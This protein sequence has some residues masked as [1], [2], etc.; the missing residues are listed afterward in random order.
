MPSGPSASASALQP[1]V[2]SSA[3][4]SVSV[5]IRCFLYKPFG[6]I[7]NLNFQIGLASARL[8]KQ[9]VVRCQKIIGRRAFRRCQMQGVQRSDVPFRQ[10]H[11]RRS[12]AGVSEMCDKASARSNPTF[13][14]LSLSGICESSSSMMS[15]PMISNSPDPASSKMLNTASAS[16]RTRFCDWSS[17]GR[18]KQQ[19]SR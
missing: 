14:R 12:I 6:R 17:K 9:I 19:T 7:F 3:G 8:A 10:F 11:A 1:A 5:F 2:R 15:L 18:F 16:S 13:S 4:L